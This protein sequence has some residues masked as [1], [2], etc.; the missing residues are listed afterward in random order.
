MQASMPRRIN[1]LRMSITDLC[2]LRCGY[3]TYWQEFERL[4]PG[5]I[6]SYEEML[7]LAAVAAK[8]GIRKI[9]ITGGEPLVR[10]E[11]VGFLQSLHQVPGIEEVCLTTNGV[12][13]PEL[14]P[15]LYEA[16]LRHLN[17]SLDTLCRER[18]REITGRDNCQEVMAGLQLALALGFQPL[19]IN[20]V[21]LKGINEDEL[22]D[23]ALLA[24]DYPI[25]VRFIELM[26]TVSQE[27]WERHF[28]PMSAVHQRLAELGQMS[29]VITA[30]TA[31]PARI[32]RISG[33]QGELGFISPMSDHH[34]SSCN[35]LRLTASGILRPCLFRETGIDLK[36]PL[37]QGAFDGL[38]AYLFQEGV[39]NKLFR[40]PAARTGEVS[41]DNFSMV[42]IGG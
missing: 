21:V 12:L 22:I 8:I 19:K 33:F 37:R 17:I 24:R 18:Y 30:A 35:R 42:G 16:G 28:L 32:F 3:C 14:A 13:L 29:P 25:Q 11:V 1:Y 27:W 34:C 20:C 39:R 7:R 31:G 10:R 36:G 26:P 23:L 4:P 41:L 6:L 5:E 40:R 38:L 2:N 9:R 15:A